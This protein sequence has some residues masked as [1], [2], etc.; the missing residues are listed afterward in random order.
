MLFYLDA[1][2]CDATLQF[3]T[4][5]DFLGSDVTETGY[6]IPSLSCCNTLAIGGVKALLFPKKILFR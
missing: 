3:I 1:K 2:Y 4:I 6:H 5:S